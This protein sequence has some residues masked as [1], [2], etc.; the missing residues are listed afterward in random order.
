MRRVSAETVEQLVESGFRFRNWR[1]DREAG[2][3]KPRSANGDQQS[4][5]GLVASAQV[6]EALLHQVCAG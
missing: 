4:V 3:A 6:V 2:P 5:N 1:R